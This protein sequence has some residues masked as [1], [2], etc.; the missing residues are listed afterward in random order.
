MKNNKS[1]RIVFEV[2]EVLTIQDLWPDGDAS[3]NP[4]IADVYKLINKH[5]GLDILKSW[6]LADGSYF[7]VM[8]R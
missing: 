1:F 2:D 7:K 6:N 5:G 8:E 3:E 4:T